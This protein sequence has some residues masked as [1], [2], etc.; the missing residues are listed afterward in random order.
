MTH[1]YGSLS[2]LASNNRRL[3]SDHLAVRVQNDDGG[4]CAFEFIVRY[5]Q[6]GGAVFVQRFRCTDGGVGIAY[7]RAQGY[8]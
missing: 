6:T 4:C 8:R 5:Q 1:A 3:T 2:I 7:L